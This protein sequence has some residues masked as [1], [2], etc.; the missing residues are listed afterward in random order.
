MRHVGINDGA[1][2]ARRQAARRVVDGLVESVAAQQVLLGQALQ[3]P[4]RLV[5]R[6]HQRQNGR[7]RSHHHVIGQPPLQTEARHAERPVLV[8]HADVEQ[9]VRAF[10]HA[11]GN[12][13]LVAILDLGAHGRLTG[14]LQQSMRVGRHDEPRHQVFEHRAAPRQQHRAARG[15]AEL[16]AQ[17]KPRFLR[18]LALRDSHEAAKAGLG[19]Q[20]VVQALVAPALGQVVADGQQAAALVVQ[21][22]VIGHCHLGQRVGQQGNQ[23]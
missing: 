12:A 11:P 19:G 16:P 21:E 7:V 17:G 1:G 9:V 5:G 4:A 13:E 18:E 2:L 22:P 6:H 14:L 23:G 10:G 8:I 20:K 15:A 3:V